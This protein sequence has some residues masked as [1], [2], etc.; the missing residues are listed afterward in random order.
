M[1]PFKRAAVCLVSDVSKFSASGCVLSAVQGSSMTKLS[2]SDFRP[3]VLWHNVV[4]SDVLV[5][6]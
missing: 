1:A 6:T 3:R 4:M 2:F 5:I